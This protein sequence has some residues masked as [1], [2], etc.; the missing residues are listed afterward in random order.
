MLCF[1]PFQFLAK[2]NPDNILVSCTSCSSQSSI[3]G[4]NGSLTVPMAGLIN[5][6]III[7]LIA[8]TGVFLIG[9]SSIYLLIAYTIYRKS[10]KHNQPTK[11]K[12]WVYLRNI[13]KFKKNI[14][15]QVNSLSTETLDKIEQIIDENK[16]N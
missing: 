12:F 2:G 5:L 6:D 11:L 9:I 4:R 7:G 3:P 15:L 10:S 16:E 13:F 14:N 8:S 1:L